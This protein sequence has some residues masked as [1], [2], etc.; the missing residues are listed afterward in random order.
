MVKIVGGVIVSELESSNGAQPAL[1][2]GSLLSSSVVV[3]G[4]TVPTW[5]LSL[6]ILAGFVLGGVP[7]GMIAT[8]V[9]GV[10]YCL[11]DSSGG[12]NPQ[13]SE[14]PI[15]LLLSL[16]K[17]CSDPRALVLRRGRPIFEGYQI[18]PNQRNAEVHPKC[19]S[20]S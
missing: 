13:V 2:D 9:L 6:P 5:T 20:F 4:F 12:S 11:S 15:L 1:S 10:G 17:F 18:I 19:N 3:Y 8:S 7:G 16:M 14:P